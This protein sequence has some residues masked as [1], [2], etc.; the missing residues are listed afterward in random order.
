MRLTLIKKYYAN[1]K[2]SVVENTIAYSWLP[3]MTK[4]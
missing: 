2:V 3:M 4:M 1:Q